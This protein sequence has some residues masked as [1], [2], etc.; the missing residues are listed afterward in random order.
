MA[1]RSERPPIPLTVVAGFLGAGKTTFI[2]RL[3]RG[4]HGR[5]ITVIVNDFGDINIDATLI[6][7]RDADVI[8]LSNGCVCCSLGGNLS[9]ALMRVCQ[10]PEP[11]DHLLIEASGVSDPS[12]CQRALAWIWPESTAMKALS[13]VVMVWQRLLSLT[14]LACCAL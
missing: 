5:R 7:H 4:G 11:P 10:A 14:S 12:P 3:L 8:A 1:A 13:V 2:N 6:T 9:A